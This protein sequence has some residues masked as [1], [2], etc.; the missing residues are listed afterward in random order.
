MVASTKLWAVVLLAILASGRRT[1]LIHSHVPVGGGTNQ[2]A[3]SARPTA[4]IP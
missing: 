3:K 2:L 4:Y 1:T